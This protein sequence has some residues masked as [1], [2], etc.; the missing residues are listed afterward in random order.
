VEPLYVRQIHLQTTSDGD[1]P[2]ETQS[3]KSKV[4]AQKQLVDELKVQWKLLWSERFDD[5]VKAEG[6][7]VNDYESLFVEQ[8]T[9]IH[10][11]KDFKPLNFKDILQHHMVENPERYIQPNVE[12][13]GWNKFIKTELTGQRIKK[14]NTRPQDIRKPKGQKLKKGGRGWLHAA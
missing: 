11:T 13:G 6:I 1:K 8:G 12:V 4:K 7:S 9:V 2:S 10:A 3:N 5:R 14:S